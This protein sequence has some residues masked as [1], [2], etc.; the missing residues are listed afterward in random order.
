MTLVQTAAIV[1]TILF[2]LLAI[3]QIS[4]LLGAPLGEFAWGG[5]QKKLDPNR[6]VGSGLNI[7]LYGVFSLMM[8]ARAGFIYSAALEPILPFALW[9]MVAFAS[10][11]IFLN[12]ITRSRKERAV[13]LPTAIVLFACQLIVAIG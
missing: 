11:G 4:L 5:Q 1:G 6:R 7:V 13:M 8:L 3:L 10:V 12:A 9:M 2:G